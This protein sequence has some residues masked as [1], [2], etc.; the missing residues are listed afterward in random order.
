MD[1]EEKGVTSVRKINFEILYLIII[2]YLNNKTKS[3]VQGPL[4]LLTNE[5]EVAIVN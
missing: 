3:R 5:K 4:G 2:N 1:A